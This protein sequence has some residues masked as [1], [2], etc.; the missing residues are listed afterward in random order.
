MKFKLLYYVSIIGIIFIPSIECFAGERCPGKYCGVP[1]F[2]RWDGCTLYSGI[3]VMYISEKTKEPLRE[4][5]GKSIQIDAKEVF[6][7]V[8][9]GDGLI[10]K[11]EYIGTAPK[12]RKWINLEG[13]KLF[14]SITVS[15][16][17]KP[18]ASIIIKNTKKETLKLFSGELALT[19]LTKLP[20]KRSFSFVSDGPSCALITRQSF[21]IGSSEPRWQGKGFSHGGPYSWTIGKENALPHSFTLEKDEKKQIDITFDLPDGE[22]DFLCGYGGGVHAEICIASNLSAFDI[23]DSKPIIVKIENRNRTKKNER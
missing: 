8:N 9:P 16:D 14:S 10:G 19:L 4:Y 13:L 20:E 7:P 21:E 2:D 22:Y 17:G 15:K 5:K 1:I 23:K 6:Q 18:V 11:Y 12:T 3:F